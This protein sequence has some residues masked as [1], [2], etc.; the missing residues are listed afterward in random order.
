M[1]S[2]ATLQPNDEVPTCSLTVDV[3]FR[4]N[5]GTPFLRG[6]RTRSTP[7]P[8]SRTNGIR[9]GGKAV[10][11]GPVCVEL[12]ESPMRSWFFGK[13]NWLV[14]TDTHLALHTSATK[15]PRSVILTS[16]I[17]KLERTDLKPYCL[18]LKTNNIQYLLTFHGDNDLYGSLRG[19]GRAAFISARP[20]ASNIFQAHDSERPLRRRHARRFPPHHDAEFRSY[21]HDST[22][23]QTRAWMMSSIVCAGNRDSTG[24]RGTHS[25]WLA[26][27]PAR[28]SPWTILLPIYRTQTLS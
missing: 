16:D 10:K 23:H 3:R 9:D 7:P 17:A 1:S 12:E 4:F 21:I 19:N 18:R 14:L 26:M 28:L 27:R 24:R 2:R 13:I 6:R 8:Y 15:P 25:C 11:Q 20:S 5:L 22:H